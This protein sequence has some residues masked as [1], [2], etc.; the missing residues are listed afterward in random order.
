MFSISK[1]YSLNFSTE[2]GIV[3]DCVG[4]ILPPQ[5][6]FWQFSRN[7]H[8]REPTLLSQN[9]NS[10]VLGVYWA[11]IWLQF[12]K[13]NAKALTHVVSHLQFISTGITSYHYNEL[14]MQK[15]HTSQQCQTLSNHIKSQPSGCTIVAD[16][17]FK[18]LD[19]SAYQ[20]TLRV[21]G[22]FH[23]LGFRLTSWHPRILGCFH[24]LQNIL[25]FQNIWT[26]VWT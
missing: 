25:K 6:T 14:S 3:E 7:Y 16:W 8:F 15:S 11:Y 26:Y 19:T 24:I 17:P 18:L 2:R 9:S 13:W 12:I 23:P 4:V 22:S 5:L 1:E 20:G 10:R 21:P